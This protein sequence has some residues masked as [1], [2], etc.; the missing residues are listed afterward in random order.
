MRLLVAHN[1]SEFVED[2]KYNF[3]ADGDLLQVATTVARAVE[4]LKQGEYDVVLTDMDF[5]DGTAL[6]LRRK[7]AE[8]DDLPTIVISKRS[9]T[10]QKVLALEYG[11][12]DYMVMPIDIFELKARIRAVNRR[13]KQETRKEVDIQP[14]FFQFFRAGFEFHLIYRTVNF[15]GQPLDLTIKEFDILVVLIM[16]MG[17]VLTRDQLSELVWTS[18]MPSNDRTVDVHIRRLREKLERVGAAQYVQTKWGEGY[19][20]RQSAY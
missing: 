17:R 20:F 11:S 15:Q 12:D 13:R 18:A 16:N 7:I 9:E 19:V 14:S 5:P 2:L 3:S 6:D 1:D 4:M 10:K 8:I